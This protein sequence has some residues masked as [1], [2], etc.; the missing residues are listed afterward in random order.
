MLRVVALRSV[1]GTGSCR[2]GH[3]QAASQLHVHLAVPSRRP[4][5]PAY[6]PALPEL[7]NLPF[8]WYTFL[9]PFDAPQ[10]GFLAILRDT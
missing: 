2:H 1:P 8:V 6:R 7:L 9:A 4:Q 5:S 3:R 10:P